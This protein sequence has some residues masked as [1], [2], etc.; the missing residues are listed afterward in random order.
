MLYPC[1]S[2]GFKFEFIL[3]IAQILLLRQ[4]KFLFGSCCA[5]QKLI[6]QLNE[7]RVLSSSYGLITFNKKSS[8]QFL[9]TFDIGLVLQLRFVVLFPF[10]ASLLLDKFKLLN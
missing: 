8:V 6:I 4:K 3:N 7:I 5:G 10:F 9:L 2:R 1:H